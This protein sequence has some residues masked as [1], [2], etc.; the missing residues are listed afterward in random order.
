MKELEK[1]LP[2]LESINPYLLSGGAGALATGLAVSRIKRD[3]K[4]SRLADL[5]RKL[6]IA[7]GGGLAAAGVHKAINTAKENFETALPEEDVSPEE[8]LV[9]TATN[10]NTA[11]VLAALGTGGTIYGLQSKADNKNLKNLRPAIDGYPGLGSNPIRTL[12]AE[13]KSNDVSRP[14]QNNLKALIDSQVEAS[15]DLI[16]EDLQKNITNVQGKLNNAQGKL[17]DL[18][19]IRKPTAAQLLENQS[20]QLEID[21]LSQDLAD[22]EGKFISKVDANKAARRANLTTQYADTGFNVKEYEPGKLNKFKRSVN[23][24]L[25]RLT[26]RT[27]LGRIGKPGAILASL[28]LPEVSKFTA[29]L[30]NS[31]PVE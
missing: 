6:A 22:A 8:K 15:K 24:Y 9:N 16:P 12:K 1:V 26:G 4:K 5:G 10:P 25:S 13:L 3:P 28:A 21:S 18:L 27:T 29:D 31:N 20:L 17:K 30:F 2:Y 7:L 19:K 11:R 14:G 23:P